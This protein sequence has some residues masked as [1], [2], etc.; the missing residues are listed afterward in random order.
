[1]PKVKA[2]PAGM[3]SITPML[4][5]ANAAAAI[6]FYQ[7]AFGAV[8]ES[9]LPGP[10]GTLLHGQVRIG[11][12]AVMLTDECPQYGAFGP[13]ALKGSPVT[14]HLYVE[15]VDAAF[16]RAQKAGATVTMPVQDMFWGDRYG[17]LQDP[18]GHSWSIATHVRDVAPA[19]LR[20]AM[21]A[22]CAS[23]TAA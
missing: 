22:A 11:D 8:E 10:D 2:I 12:S 1:M 21:K 5:C 13:K 20:E 4:V 23:A 16:A 14:I 19:D 9:R 18:F 17:V 3:R 6:D 15:D 7:K